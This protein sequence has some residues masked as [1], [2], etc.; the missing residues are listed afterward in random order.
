MSIV[1]IGT[2]LYTNNDKLDDY[3]SAWYIYKAVSPHKPN[4]K[5]R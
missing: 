1:A 4:R 2:D 5:S 3:I